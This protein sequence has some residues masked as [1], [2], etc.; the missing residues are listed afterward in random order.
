MNEYW[1]KAIG[2]VVFGGGYFGAVWLGLGDIPAN[3]F[4][5]FLSLVWLGK[6]IATAIGK[7][8]KA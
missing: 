4:L 2:T 7:M 1:V 3:I 8:F 6:P 5:S